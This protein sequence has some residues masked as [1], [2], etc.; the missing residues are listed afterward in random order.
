MYRGGRLIR[1]RVVSPAVIASRCSQTRSICQLK[2]CRRFEHGPG[3]F[4]ER[5]QR[6]GGLAGEEFILE[7]GVPTEWVMGHCA[8]PR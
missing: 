8:L 3:L 6:A 5:P 7:L 2:R 4:N 1:S